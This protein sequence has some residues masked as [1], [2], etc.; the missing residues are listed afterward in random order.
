MDKL[1]CGDVGY[2]W[3][4]ETRSYWRKTLAARQEPTTN[5]IHIAVGWNLTQATLVG[6]KSSQHYAIPAPQMHCSNVGTCLLL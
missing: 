1:E 3:K 2:F 5:S 6:S 4:E